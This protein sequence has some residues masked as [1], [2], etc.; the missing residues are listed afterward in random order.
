MYFRTDLIS[1]P[2]PKISV[3]HKKT[4]MCLNESFLDPFKIIEET[5]LNE[6]QNV[7]VNRY[8]S[9]IT[10][11]LKNELESY[12]GVS[13][14]Q[15]LFGNGADE[16]LYNLFVSVRENNK[17]FAV[18]LSPSYFDYSTYSKAVGLGMKFVKLDENFDFSV[19]EYIAKASDDDCKLAILCTPNNPTGN[20]ISDEKI[21]KVLSELNKPVLI[22]ETYFEFSGK[23]YI[24]YLDKYPNLIIIRTF[25]KAFSSA[26]L[27]FGMLISNAENIIQIKKTMT[28]F[29]SS[30][31]IQTFAHSILK[32]KE[33][34]IEHNKNIVQMR[35]RMYEQLR[36]FA[37]IKVYKSF[38]NFLLFTAGEYTLDLFEFLMKNEIAI[39][40]VSSGKILNNHLRVTISS[41][42]DNDLFIRILHDFFNQKGEK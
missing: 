14:K 38:T 32:N 2:L 10:D 1:R 40:N 5:F 24:D 25:S 33:I 15:F 8:F 42:E 41:L 9:P 6:M 16:M 27:R 20:F 36:E 22:D 19:T 31:L 28:F 7:H 30:L 18:S 4:M 37:Q 13:N 12:L 21:F 39:R 29:N 11:K 26:G 23:T 35:N 3:P 17:S 34:F